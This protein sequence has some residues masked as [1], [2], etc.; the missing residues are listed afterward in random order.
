MSGKA[1]IVILAGVLALA[2][3]ASKPH[4][5]SWDQ[6]ANER[7]ADHLFYEAQRVVN[8]SGGVD[9]YMML[10]RTATSI[11]P[12]DKEMGAEYGKYQWVM[13]ADSVQGAEGVAKM[14]RYFDA[15]PEDFY[16]SVAYL[17]VVRNLKDY[18]EAVRVGAVID[19]LFPTK[20]EMSMDYADDLAMLGVMTAD[21]TLT[22]KAYG[23]LE[24]I[25]Q[26]MGPDAWVVSRKVRQLALRDDS[27]GVLREVQRFLKQAPRESSNLVFAAR[28][29]TTL[30]MIDTALTL[31]NTATRLDSTNGNAY[32]GRAQI[33]GGQGDSAAY[34][35]EIFSLMELPGA[36]VDIK[37]QLIT[38]YVRSLYGDT[39]PGSQ[40]RIKRMFNVLTDNHPLEPEIRSM[41]G[42]YL[43]LIHDWKGAVEQFGY[44]TDLAP[45]DPEKWGYYVTSLVNMPDYEKAVAMARKTEGL[46]P[47]TALEMRRLEFYALHQLGRTAE[48]VERVNDV[49]QS[50]TITGDQR[51]EL[52]SL[53]GDTYYQDGDTTL[54]AQYYQQAIEA[55]EANFMAMNN[56]AYHLAVLNRDLDRA[57]QLAHKA[58]SAEPDNPTYLDTYAW[59]LFRRKDYAKAKEY[60]DLTMQSHEGDEDYEPSA[61]E[62]GHAGDIYFMNGE[63]EK[64]LEFWQKAL[65]LS[66]DDA[67]LQRKVKHKTFFYE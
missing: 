11:S 12:Q 24:R 40:E 37:I 19:S 20:T 66:P 29:Y 7:L 2:V 43:A 9:D 49:L 64:A 23:I 14:R 56:Y 35:R 50:D 21:S 13:D 8:D 4:G 41:H 26:G 33:Y 55:N 42:S 16:M 27:A 45:D 57:L 28:I 54:S 30:D 60:I 58:V 34:D 65:E 22:A 36:D 15:H 38:G 63:P 53:L 31:Y 39:T 6:D 51:S 61:E 67:L 62:Y 48:G 17:N 47:Q 52:L 3:G 25:E 44:A 10:L 1:A 32:L 18:P 5:A 59:V 46:F